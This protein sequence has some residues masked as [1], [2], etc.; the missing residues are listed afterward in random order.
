MP[1]THCFLIKTSSKNNSMNR[2]SRAIKQSIVSIKNECGCKHNLMV[3]SHL[4][5]SWG[6]EL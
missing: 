2:E 1:I 6:V 4:I 5:S 3:V